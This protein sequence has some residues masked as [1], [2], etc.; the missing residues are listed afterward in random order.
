MSELPRV[1]TWRIVPRS[2]RPRSAAAIPVSV[3][4]M[5]PGLMDER[6]PPEVALLLPNGG[7]NNAL[8]SA[9]SG[10]PGEAP[11]AAIGLFMADPFLNPPLIARRLEMLGRSWVCNLPSGTQ[12]DVEFSALLGDVNLDHGREVEQL[13]AF[14]HRGHRILVVTAD[15]ADAR[16][17]AT[18]NPD[19]LFVMPRVADFAA[20]FPSFR[21]RGSAISEVCDVVRA[22][23]W[24]GPVLGLASVNE[25]AHESMWPPQL[26]GVVVRPVPVSPEA[27]I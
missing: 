27:R 1:L 26:A 19:A 12:Q 25:A 20:G 22:A 17:A 13:A 18:I 9:A 5:A 24:T 8:L 2:G 15:A 3:L 4:T 11:G 21:Q 6:V 10:M 14:G 23:G 16:R 7:G